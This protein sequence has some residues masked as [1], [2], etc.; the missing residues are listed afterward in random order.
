LTTWGGLANLELPADS[1]IAVVGI[2]GL[3]SLGIQ[4]AK[5]FGY[6]VAAIDTREEGRSLAAEVPN[7]A[8]LIVDPSKEGSLDKIRSWSGKMGLAGVVITTDK[9]EATEWA[10]Q[11]VR[12]R[13]IVVEIGLPTEPFPVEAFNLVFRE[14]T[15]KGS[16]LSSQQQ[17][18]DMMK[19]VDKYKVRTQINA[20][21]MEEAVNLPDLYMDPHL[22]GRLVVVMDE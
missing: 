8:D 5:A 10:L 20:V 21:S 22:K 9:H 13:G 6:R 15:F 19:A 2:G 7:P 1:P 12:P 18:E 17:A 14:L 4:L 16:L 11:A 3:G